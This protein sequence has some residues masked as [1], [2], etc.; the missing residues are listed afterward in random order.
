M[1]RPQ[2]SEQDQRVQPRL[3]KVAVRGQSPDEQRNRVDHRRLPLPGSDPPT[4]PTPG[5]IWLGLFLM[6]LLVLGLVATLFVRNMWPVTVGSWSPSALAGGGGAALQLMPYTQRRFVEFAGVVV[7]AVATAGVGRNSG[8]QARRAHRRACKR[9]AG[10]H[11]T[12]V[13]PMRRKPPWALVATSSGSDGGIARHRS[14]DFNSG[15]RADVGLQEGAWLRHE[16]RRRRRDDRAAGGICSWLF[17]A[18][19]TKPGSG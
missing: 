5:A 4:Q 3:G 12:T 17:R 18:W 1:D 9:M 8:T 11:L 16:L 10:P 19:S 14:G 6:A 13:S 7:V 15:S 2:V